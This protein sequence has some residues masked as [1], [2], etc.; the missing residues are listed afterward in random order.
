[1][2]QYYRHFKGGKYKLLAYGQD[3]ET[4]AP[5]V[6]YQALYGEHKIWVRPKELFFGTVEKDGKVIRRFSEISKED[7]YGN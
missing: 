1:M 3:S 6:I 7:A 4:L 5:V 2:E